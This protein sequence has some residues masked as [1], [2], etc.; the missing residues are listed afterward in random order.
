[1]K[2]IVVAVDSFKGSLSSMAIADAVEEG[3][4]S[5]S[6][7]CE[8]IKLPIADGGEGT[9]EAMVN[10]TGGEFITTT[11]CNPFMQPIN[12]RYGILGDRKT[13]VIEMA[14]ASG[15]NLIPFSWGM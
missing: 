6:P 3:I 11:V 8:V 12:A 9:V 4:H 5:I 13:A 14:A 15:L 1:M 7:D 2:K 10:A